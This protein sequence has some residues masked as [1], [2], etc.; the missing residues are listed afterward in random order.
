MENQNFPG[1][2]F[3][4]KSGFLVGSFG[5]KKKSGFFGGS[6]WVEKLIF[7]G[8]GGDFF[9]GKADFFGQKN[10]FSGWKNLM[11]L[12][13]FFCLEKWNFWVEFMVEKSDFSRFLA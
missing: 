13:I 6:F 2:L 3:G 9:A 7:E 10:R 5:G 1:E 11:L 8:N 4:L 12:K